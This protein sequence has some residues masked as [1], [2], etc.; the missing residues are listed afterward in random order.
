MKQRSKTGGQ[1]YRGVQYI[2]YVTILN[3]NVCFRTRIKLV[4]LN[5]KST[6]VHMLLAYHSC[7]KE[8]T[9]WSHATSVYYI[10]ATPPR[11]LTPAL[12]ACR[13]R[14]PPPPCS[15]TIRRLLTSCRRPLPPQRNYIAAD[16]VT[17]SSSSPR[18]LLSLVSPSTDR[19]CRHQPP[20]SSTNHSGPHA[21]LP[22]A[23]SPSHRHPSAAFS[24][25]G[26]RP[27]RR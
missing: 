7:Q 9:S 15:S 17:V 8:N 25:Q 27:V 16:I 13:C 11:R 12:V 22:S 26:C 19:S 1:K 23:C 20:L 6:P 3:I 10:R 4:R 14:P 5:G 2:F 21:S 18:S 24:D